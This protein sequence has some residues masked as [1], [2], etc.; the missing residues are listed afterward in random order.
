MHAV[1]MIFET[2]HLITTKEWASSLTE[3]SCDWCIEIVQFTAF[4]RPSPHF[5]QVHCLTRTF[6]PRS[7][8]FAEDRSMIPNAVRFWSHILLLIPSIICSL[9]VLYCL[10]F[11]RV[12]RRSLHHHVIIL[13]LSIGLISQVTNYPSMLY[14]YQYVGVWRRSPIF[15]AIWGFLEGG[16]YATQTFLFAWATVER[17]ILI[18]HDRWLATK[19]KRAF[20]Y[21]LP[22]FVLLLYCLVYYSVM[23]FFPPCSNVYI[24]VR[25]TCAYP[26]IVMNYQFFV[27]DTVVQQILPVFVIVLF[28]MLL[29]VRVVWQKHRLRRPQQ[30]RKHRKM[31]IQL[32]SISLLYL[33]FS[34]PYS[35]VSILMLYAGLSVDLIFSL[36]DYSVFLIDFPVL[37]FPFICL[38]S[39][40]DVRTRVMKIFR[41]RRP[42]RA[43]APGTRPNTNPRTTL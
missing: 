28:S 30:W 42:A 27:Y 14:F 3:M 7:E 20:V 15:C 16:F 8:W 37:F 24:Y 6:S 29:L 22:M 38:L 21:Y 23:Y 2:P 19:M 34:F 11:D 10:L 13:L 12:L 39:F 41:C 4:S 40:T 9:L 32:L 25:N 33:F 18:F 1:T 36:Y 35:I 43:V 31:T 5:Q 26:C 17:H